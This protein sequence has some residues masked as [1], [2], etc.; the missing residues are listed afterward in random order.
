MMTQA[1]SAGACGAGGIAAGGAAR[2]GR[3]TGAALSAAGRHLDLQTPEAYDQALAEQAKTNGRKELMALRTGCATTH[4]ACI[5]DDDD[6]EDMMA[7]FVE[8]TEPQGDKVKVDLLV[9]FYKK[10]ANA[11]SWRR[12]LSPAGPPRTAW[13]TTTRSG[14]DRFDQVSVRPRTSNRRSGRRRGNCRQRLTT[15]CSTRPRRQAP[16][17][18]ANLAPSARQR[19]RKLAAAVHP[20]T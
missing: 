4:A 19:A 20:V 1:D 13:R 15:I 18:G 16:F 17:R 2:R 11:A 12:S 6:I 5:V 14:V 9:E 10:D 3:P 8:V 7:P